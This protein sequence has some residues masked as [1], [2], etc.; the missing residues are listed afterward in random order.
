MK[1]CMLA[2]SYIQG[3]RNVGLLLEW[4]VPGYGVP[5]KSTINEP[6][7]ITIMNA[8]YKINN[9][10]GFFTRGKAHSLCLTFPSEIFLTHR[11]SFTNI[12]ILYKL[13]KKLI[14]DD[15]FLTT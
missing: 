14:I 12:F 1:V 15:E 9:S 11:S 8:E 10:F 5:I 4:L 3:M 7:R 6:K 13:K 2:L